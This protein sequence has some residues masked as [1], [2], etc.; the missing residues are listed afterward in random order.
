MNVRI[1]LVPRQVKT[2]RYDVQRYYQLRRSGLCTASEASSVSTKRSPV[3]GE[4][5]KALNFLIYLYLFMQTFMAVFAFFDQGLHGGCE[6]FVF[7]VGDAE[8]AF[9]FESI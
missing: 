8:D 9:A 2:F 7:A 5:W 4:R 6:V 1:I 3:R